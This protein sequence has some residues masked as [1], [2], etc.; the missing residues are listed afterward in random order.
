MNALAQPARQW[1]AQTALHAKPTPRISFATTKIDCHCPGCGERFETETL[2]SILPEIGGKRWLYCSSECQ[3]ASHPELR[4]P[5][6]QIKLATAAELKLKDTEERAAA[7]LRCATVDGHGYPAR[8][9]RYVF[10]SLS[11]SA[12]AV[13]RESLG[14]VPPLGGRGIGFMGHSEAGKSYIAHELARRLWMA[15]YDVAL[16]SMPALISALKG[17]VEISDR[18]AMVERCKSAGIV[19]FDDLGMEQHTDNSL[20][21]FYA[22][23]QH[24]EEHER[25]NIYTCN[26]GG[27]GLKEKFAESPALYN[28]LKRTADWRGV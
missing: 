15:G 9:Q 23:L 7:W 25:A 6:L 11:P 14:W 27:A 10:S 20:S 19:L 2:A 18:S 22:I 1:A 26:L 3:Q 28:R 5:A 16:C 4:K 12:Q 24:R 17:N 8:Y 21:A 13:A